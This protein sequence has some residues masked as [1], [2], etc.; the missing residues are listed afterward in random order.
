MVRLFYLLM[1]IASGPAQA[2]DPCACPSA[3]QVSSRQSKECQRYQPAKLNRSSFEADKCEAPQGKVEPESGNLQA[4]LDKASPIKSYRAILDYVSC[5]R[6]KEYQFKSGDEQFCHFKMTASPY[7]ELAAQSSS[8][9]PAIL[10]CMVDAESAFWPS[11]TSR[12][13]AYGYT[14]F[15]S[16]TIS[17]LS[18]VVKQPLAE[19]RANYDRIKGQVDA[20]QLEFDSLG[21]DIEPYRAAVYPLQLVAREQQ[22]EIV[23]A[24]RALKKKPRDAAL[25]KELARAKAA[26]AST[27]KELAEERAKYPEF[28]VR[29]E[30]LEEDLRTRKQQ[31]RGHEA[32]LRAKEVWDA[33]WEGSTPIPSSVTRDTV[34]CPRIAFAVAAMKQ[35]LDLHCMFTEDEIGKT[36]QGHYYVKTLKVDPGLD[37]RA[38]MQKRELDTGIYLSGAYNAG[39]GAFPAKCA[40][41]A[42][43]ARCLSFRENKLPEETIRHMNAIK[44]CAESDSTKPLR[45]KDDHTKPAENANCEAMK[46]GV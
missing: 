42:G 19:Q 34:T 27:R 29:Y 15:M 2:D 44:N 25:K 22:S 10:A 24:T 39:I 32:R 18:D 28:V 5:Q 4:L 38:A 8:M 46:C 3:D 17:D 37:E 40:P 43:L 1:I 11:P 33:Y 31:L 41:E 6:V 45:W 23:R 21:T 36:D 7:I 12:A 35:V 20:I 16:S 30:K 13:G 9:R 14:Q 26:L